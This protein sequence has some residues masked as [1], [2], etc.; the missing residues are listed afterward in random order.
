[1]YAFGQVLKG[2]LF[3]WGEK[4]LSAKAKETISSKK[5]T[6]MAYNVSHEIIVA[7]AN[8]CSQREGFSKNWTVTGGP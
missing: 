3:S 8:K 6:G 7:R 5:G 2:C 4:T 1:M